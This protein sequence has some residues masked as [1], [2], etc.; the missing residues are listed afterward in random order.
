[1]ELE[2]KELKMTR[3]SW[4]AFFIAQAKLIASM[5]TC[6]RRQVG[7]VLVDKDNIQLSCGMNGVPPGFPHCNE[8]PADRCAGADSPSGTNLDSCLATHAEI[9][10]LLRCTDISKICTVY[11]TVSPCISCVKALLGTGATRIVF[12]DE[13]P[14][15]ESKQLWLKM[16]RVEK[17]ISG[18]VVA[19]WNRTWEKYDPTVTD[20]P[21]IVAPV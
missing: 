16:M 6:A 4:D 11:V 8:L 3:P 12:V 10:A 9:N 15:P 2:N 1:L 14:H 7:A 20:N 19:Y 17:D 18:S 21:A 13:Y 5:G